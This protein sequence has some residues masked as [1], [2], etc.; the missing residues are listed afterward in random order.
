MERKRLFQMRIGKTAIRNQENPSYT[1][2][3]SLGTG[4]RRNQTYMI[5]ERPMNR[6]CRET[7]VRK[8][9]VCH[10]RL[11][12][13]VENRYQASSWHRQR[14]LAGS[15]KTFSY[16]GLSASRA[17]LTGAEKKE[18]DLCLERSVRCSATS[19]VPPRHEE[20]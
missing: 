19:L 12:H 16:A 4:D 3:G 20:A 6:W 9:H 18:K 8:T 1:L 17:I 5:A 11:A 7:L 14:F 13:A 15:I 2:T 10:D